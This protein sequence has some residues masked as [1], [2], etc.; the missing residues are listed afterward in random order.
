MPT[1]GDLFAYGMSL[2]L[3]NSQVISLLRKG[4]FEGLFDEKKYSDYMGYLKGWSVRYTQ[5]I[6]KYDEKVFTPSESISKKAERVMRKVGEREWYF[7]PIAHNS[8]TGEYRA[9]ID[10]LHEGEELVYAGVSVKDFLSI[11]S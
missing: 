2:G 7:S 8:A 1:K 6:E 3:T 11:R 10:G 4:G 5:L 9:C